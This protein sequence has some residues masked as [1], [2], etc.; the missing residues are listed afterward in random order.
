MFTQVCVCILFDIMSTVKD[1]TSTSRDDP[2]LGSSAEHVTCDICAGTLLARNL[3]RHRERY[4][5]WKVPPQNLRCQQVSTASSVESSEDDPSD[6]ARSHRALDPVVSQ[7]AQPRGESEPYVPKSLRRR[8]SISDVVVDRDTI[9]DTVSAILELHHDFSKEAMLSLLQR[10]FPEVPAELRHTFVDVATSAAQYVA[11]IEEISRTFPNSGC[12]TDIEHARKAARSLTS[13]R[14]GPRR[15][16]VA[17]RIWS[18]DT[19]AGAAV[20]HRQPGS[21][22]VNPSPDA[23]PPRRQLSVVEPLVPAKE[24][25]TLAQA[26]ETAQPSTKPADILLMSLKESG[27]P[28][29]GDPQMQPECML[30]ELG[31]PPVITDLEVADL[32]MFHQPTSEEAD[33]ER[34]TSR[35][36]YE[37]ADRPPSHPPTRCREDC[38]PTGAVHHSSTPRYLH[39]RDDSRAA[40][41]SASRQATDR[42]RSTSTTRVPTERR[43][44]SGTPQHLTPRRVTRRDER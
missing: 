3:K 27:I 8:Q 9:D 2:P 43:H 15:S 21:L 5:S 1:F 32:P 36:R 41:T 30:E 13:W 34:S 29:C 33:S 39:Y 38:G 44:Y 40:A 14:L 12:P 26:S 16:S 18:D 19:V 7:A 25:S 35:R 17:Q 11:G 42:D 24:A 10:D 37:D 6:I 23:A 22:P 31:Q 28:I 20:T 4:H